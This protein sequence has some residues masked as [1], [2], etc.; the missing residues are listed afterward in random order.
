VTRIN[1]GGQKRI[2]RQIQNLAVTAVGDAQP[3]P[4]WRKTSHGF[5]YTA[6]LRHHLWYI[7]GLKQRGFARRRRAVEFPVDRRVRRSP[8][9]S[10][11]HPYDLLVILCCTCERHL[12]DCRPRLWRTAFLDVSSLNFGGA[13][14]GAAVFLA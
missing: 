13:L 4:A 9:V 14:T 7:L 5:P 12:A 10:R 6:P 2:T 3:R 1:L 11:E 8:I